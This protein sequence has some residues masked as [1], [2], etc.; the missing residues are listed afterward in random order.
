MDAIEKRARELFRRVLPYLA[1]EAIKYVDDGSNE[2]LELSREIVELLSSAP[3]N[4]DGASLTPPEGSDQSLLELACTFETCVPFLPPVGQKN[5]AKAV[6][7]LRAAA[8]GYVLVPVETN[9]EAERYRHLRENYLQCWEDSHTEEPS[10]ANFCFE[11]KGWD[12]DFA[13]DE[14]IRSAASEAES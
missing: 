14:A 8:M 4:E 9:R 5:I 6:A 2:P 7:K 10:H 1:D 11:C 3:A 12:M 13:I